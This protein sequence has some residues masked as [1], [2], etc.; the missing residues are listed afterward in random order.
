MGFIKESISTDFVIAQ[1][2]MCTSFPSIWLERRR[3][4]NNNIENSLAI[5]GFYR[6]WSQNGQ[7]SEA[8]QMAR[9]EVFSNQINEA[10]LK[11]KNIIVL[12]D[13]NLDSNKWNEDKFT[14]KHVSKILRDS[15][16]A[17]DITVH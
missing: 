17:N 13:A 5:G 2:L 4:G 7:N 6:E 1:D 3:Q 15:L 16:E 9:M 11:C 14:H 12:G 10:S 8:S